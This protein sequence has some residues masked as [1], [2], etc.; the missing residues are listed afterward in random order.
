M[1]RHTAAVE[2]DKPRDP[3]AAAAAGAGG[4]AAAAAAASAGQRG[5]A[6]SHRGPAALPPARNLLGGQDPPRE[7]GDSVSGGGVGADRALA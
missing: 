6:H 5:T 1:E 4:G 3:A 2:K 7:G